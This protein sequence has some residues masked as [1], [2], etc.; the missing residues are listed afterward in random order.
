MLD[1]DANTAKT[2]TLVAVILQAIYF[3]V[4]VVILVIAL[5]AVLTTAGIPAG[6]NLLSGATLSA[7]GIITIVFV[8]VFVVGLLWLLLDYYLVYRRLL[9][10]RVHDAEAPSLALGILQIVLGG[11]VPG[12]LLIIAYIKIRDSEARMMR[13]R[14]TG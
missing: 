1:P 7:A 13:A 4:G 5:A 2:L 10:E 11:V 6:V 12:I 14:P 8:P 3:A 9:E